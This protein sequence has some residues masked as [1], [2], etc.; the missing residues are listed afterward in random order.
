MRFFIFRKDATTP[1][2]CNKIGCTSAIQ[3]SL[4]A[5]GLHNLCNKIGC[6]SAIQASLIAFGLHNLCIRLAAPQQFKQA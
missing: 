6:T 4:I 3:A 2:L 1:Y 5:F